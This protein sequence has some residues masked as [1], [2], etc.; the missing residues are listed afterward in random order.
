MPLSSSRL[1]AQRPDPSAQG[2]H[3]L[4]DACWDA[5]AHAAATPTV[6]IDFLINHV[7]QRTDYD[8]LRLERLEL[9]LVGLRVKQ[10]D[11]AALIVGRTAINRLIDRIV[12]AF[13]AGVITTNQKIGFLPRRRDDDAA[14]AA[15]QGAGQ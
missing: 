13:D 6:L 3:P 8:A 15:K 5:G 10:P 2:R 4:L 7:R 14:Y 11:D 9:W 1:A 12:D